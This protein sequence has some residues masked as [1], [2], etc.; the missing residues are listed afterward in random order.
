MKLKTTPISN[1]AS[2]AFMSIFTVLAVLNSQI[3]VFYIIFL[4]WFDEFLRTVFSFLFYFFKREK[5]TLPHVYFAAIKSKMFLLFLYVIFIIIFFGF[6]LDWKKSDLIFINLT[7]LA[8][9]NTLFN[10]T[11]VTFLIRELI[12]FFRNELNSVSLNAMLS[13]EIIILHISIIIGMFVWGFLPKDFYENSNS[14]L[15]SGLVI[16]PFLLLKL[17]FE[18]KLMNSNSSAGIDEKIY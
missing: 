7:V 6:I 2:L 18:I 3:S 11:I 9:K 1:Y 8:F 17:F 12:L 14:N 15:L 10:F 4:F 13:K 16:A 5:L